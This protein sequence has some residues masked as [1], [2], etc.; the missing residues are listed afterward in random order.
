MTTSFI[1]AS[2]AAVAATSA[3]SR[4][5]D[6]LGSACGWW[7]DQGWLAGDPLRRIRRRSRTPDRTRALARAE[8][9]TLLT[10][11]VLDLRERTLVAVA[12]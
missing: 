6:A 7:R 5:N 4:S 3:S 2:W 8:V 10:R 1:A 12:V 11:P 9:E